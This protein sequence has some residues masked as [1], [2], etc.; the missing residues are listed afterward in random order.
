MA[1]SASDRSSSLPSL[2]QLQGISLVV[3][4]IAVAA[5][6]LLALLMGS[7]GFFQSYLLAFLFWLGLSLGCLVMLFVQ[8]L[9]GGSW[10][11]LIRRPLEA[12]VAVLP[13]LA[14]LFIPLLFGLGSLYEWTHAEYIET[15]PLVGAK[16]SYLNVPFFIVRAVLY[17]AIWIGGAL[18]FLRMSNRQDRELNNS[19]SIAY[20]M[21]SLSAA[22]IIIY[23]MT[24]TF[25]GIDWGMSLTPTWF[26]GIYSVILMIG[27]AINATAFIIVVLILLA[28]AVPAVNEL[29]TAKRLQDLGNFLMAFIMFWAYVSFSQLII[30]WSN[31][32]VETSPW[33]VVRLNT[34]WAYLS[35]FLLV[36]GF[37]APFAILFSRW[38]KRK[39]A[40]LMTV[41]IWAIIVR[42]VDLFWIIV[43][44]FDR[45]GSQLLLLDVLLV[46]GLGGLWLA[47]FTRSLAS[48]PILPLHDPRLTPD[49]HALHTV[50]SLHGKPLPKGTDHA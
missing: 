7:E 14:I 50:P 12:A 26:S 49:S 36:F 11:A 16:S 43:P 47:A 39:R 29:L 21:K 37:F 22:W 17:F 25:A 18:Y 24:M 46:V 2:G 10:G 28:R 5:A 3:G 1:A 35:A 30:L 23:V 15:H 33:Y 20:R 45:S 34:D 6:L 32:T 42:L 13:V 41:A 19:G 44:S 9:A 48:R 8:H 40:A 31:N 4:A 27:Q 38:V